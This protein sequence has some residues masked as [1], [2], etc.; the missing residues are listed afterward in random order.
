MPAWWM[1]G[2]LKNQ[3][4]LPI[5]RSEERRAFAHVLVR[6][7]RRMHGELPCEEPR[8]PRHLATYPMRERL[9]DLN[10]RAGVSDHNGI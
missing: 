9:H 7:R 5:E 6:A 4:R 1:Q 2:W 8:W 10:A 3:T